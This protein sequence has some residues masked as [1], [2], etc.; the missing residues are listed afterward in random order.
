MSSVTVRAARAEDAAAL[1]TLLD[2]SWLAHWAPHVL[3]ASVERYQREL[4]AHGYVD[5]LWASFMVAEREGSVVGMYHLEG[6]YLH[7]IH[8]APAATRSGVGGVLMQHAEAQG[9]ARLEVRVF[10][11]NALQ[12][13]QHRGWR[14][15]DEVDGSEM[16]TPTRSIIMARSA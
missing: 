5:A 13:Y 12:F 8:V 15:V 9:A 16:G 4:P 6:D 1:K 11:K 14:Q 2:Q 7:A 10:N 3:A